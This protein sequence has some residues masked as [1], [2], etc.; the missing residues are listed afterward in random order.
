MATLK[1]IAGKNASW[2]LTELSRASDA[3]L[4]TKEQIIEPLRRF[5]GS[6][7]KAIYDQARQLVQEQED[8]FAYV[9]TGEVE[10]IK[11]LLTEN[12]PWQGNRLQ[13]AKPQ[14]EALQQAI[15]NQL[16]SEKATAVSR[17]AELEQRLQGSNEYGSLKP[18][19]QA[20]LA[21]PFVE[22]QQSMQGQKRIAMIRDQLRAFE[23]NQYAQLLLKLERLARPQPVPDPIPPF[24][25]PPAGN[26][27]IDYPP[28][29]STEPPK[30]AEPRL[31]PARSITVG[32]SKPW[33]ASESELDDYLR[34]LREAWLKEIQAGNRVQI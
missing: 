34:Q 16:T 31:V 30:V 7:Q 1:E 5:M 2:F 27:D 3:M 24:S 14:L 6:P 22:A 10:A 18:E 26:Q 8:N 12:K 25:P 33:L 11:A 23:D 29:P 4:D 17:L 20:Q 32:Y 28:P 21:V 15:A 9:A 13:Q 19:Q